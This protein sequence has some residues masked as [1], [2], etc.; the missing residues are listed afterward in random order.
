LDQQPVFYLFVYGQTFWSN[1]FMTVRPRNAGKSA[2][3]RDAWLEINLSAIEHNYHEIKRTLN[4]GTK[5]MAVIKSD[6]YG[7]GA[8]VIGPLLE[9]C[10]AEYFGVASVDEGIQLREAGV[11]NEILIL[12]PAPTWALLRALTHNLQIT[13]S[14]LQQLTELQKLIESNLKKVKKPILVQIKINTGMNRNG[15]KWNTEAVEL[16]NK[17]LAQKEVFS[18]A[19]VYSHLACDGN[20]FFTQVQADRFRKVINEFAPDE[21]GSRHLVASSSLFGREN[22]QFEMVR[23]GLSMYGL[24]SA[25]KLNLRPALSLKARISQIQKIEADEGV[26]YNLIWKADRKSTIGLLP[27]G[28]ADG[29]KRGLSNRIRA[30]YDNQFI[31]QVGTISMDQ[32][33][34]DLSALESE[35]KTGD[36]VLL[37]GEQ[38]GHKIEMREWAQILGT[39]EYEVACD[40]RARLPRVYVRS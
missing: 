37:L 39:I 15:S 3:S 26:G 19:G 25:N 29:I 10:G 9:A 28:Y 23:I 21:L 4:P 24:G 34:F 32:I 22:L 11:K 6:A 7:H 2:F 35:P 40:L 5:M 12:S 33:S 8:S 30:L 1:I 16:I 13:I 14:N 38:N 17:V 36:V 31:N 18:L 27:L 20:N